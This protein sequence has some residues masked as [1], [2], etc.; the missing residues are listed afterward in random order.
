M[1]L[2]KLKNH[3]EIDHYPHF[4]FVIQDNA[5]VAY[6]VNRNTTSPIHY[7]YQPRAVPPRVKAALEIKP[8]QAKLHSEVSAFRKARGILNHRKP[9]VMVN[10]R[11]NRA[12]R[13]RLSRPCPPCYAIITALGCRKFYYSHDNGFSTLVDL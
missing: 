8:Y 1:A 13:L 6:G 10:V 3:P 5:I 7:G 11:L 2:S 4:S 12:G 9:W